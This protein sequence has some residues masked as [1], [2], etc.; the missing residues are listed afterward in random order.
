MS[1][2]PIDY[3]SLVP[4]SQEVAKV[5]QVEN[6]KIKFQ[7]EQ[8]VLQQNKQIERNIQKVRNTNKSKNLTV[9]INKKNKNTHDSKNSKQR[10]KKKKDSVCIKKDKGVTIDIKI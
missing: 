3:T 7:V 1:I 4:K 6:N 5:K 2:K 9:D 10:E 8:G